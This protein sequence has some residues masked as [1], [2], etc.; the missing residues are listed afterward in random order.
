MATE[1]IRTALV[2][3]P[4]AKAARGSSSAYRCS[5]PAPS[6]SRPTG[7]YYLY[8]R[9]AR[10]TLDDL[11][12]EM[13]RPQFAGQGYVGTAPPSAGP[14]SHALPSA[15]AVAPN[16]PPSAAAGAQ[17]GSAPQGA[18]QADAGAP[19]GSAAVVQA[20][21]AAAPTTP[22]Q[23]TLGAAGV[24][25]VRAQPDRGRNGR[26][27]LRADGRLRRHVPGGQR[28]PPSSRPRCRPRTCRGHGQARSPPGHACRRRGL[29]GLARHAPVHVA[30]HGASVVGRS[31]QAGGARPAAG[32]DRSR[33]RCLHRRGRHVLRPDARGPRLRRL[34]GEA[35]QD[36]PPSRSTPSSTS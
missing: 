23:S 12:F 3:R 27:R 21:A 10:S 26:G 29:V 5:R 6:C 15:S 20:P 9:L 2:T 1:T 34:A 33:G 11:D 28:G 35:Y 4:R 13:E 24:C 7:G 36:T 17:S 30:R 16:E 18:V 19:A 22:R 32:R 14:P 8:G 25:A 31:R